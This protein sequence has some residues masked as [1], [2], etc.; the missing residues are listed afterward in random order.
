MPSVERSIVDRKRVRHDHSV[1]ISRIQA[2]SRR[3]RESLDILEKDTEILAVDIAVQSILDLVG[4][5]VELATS[6]EFKGILQGLYR[7]GRG[8]SVNS[9]LREFRLQSGTGLKG[10]DRK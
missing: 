5:R 6:L 9:M 7:E 8:A 1:R 4:R 3:L 2:R 10:G